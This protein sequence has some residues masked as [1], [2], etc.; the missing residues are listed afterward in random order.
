MYNPPSFEAPVAQLDRVPGYEPGGRRFESFRARHF[1]SLYQ[2]A[3]ALSRCMQ[4]LLLSNC[5]RNCANR[6]RVSGV[7]V[8]LLCCVIIK[9]MILAHCLQD[10][11]LPG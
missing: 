8:L 2:Q 1:H 3:A 6:Y 11:R 5:A 10:T 4:F 9:L 7:R